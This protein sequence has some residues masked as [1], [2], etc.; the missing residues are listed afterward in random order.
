MRWAARAMTGTSMIDQV[1]ARSLISR[2]R[3]DIDP[4]V[5]N[6]LDIWTI[7]IAVAINRRSDAKQAVRGQ[8]SQSTC[9]RLRV[10]AINSRHH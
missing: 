4:V 1:Q 3:G 2:R 6:A 8:E 5:S 7:L 10:P 9:R